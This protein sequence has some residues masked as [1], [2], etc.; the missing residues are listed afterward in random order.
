MSKA[1]TFS[2]PPHCLVDTVLHARLRQTHAI[3]P[4][5]EMIQATSKVTVSRRIFRVGV[6]NQRFL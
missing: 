1:K 4:V 6:Y 5:D 2:L 3:Y